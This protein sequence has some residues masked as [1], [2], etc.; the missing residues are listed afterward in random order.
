MRGIEK[1]LQFTAFQAA[2]CNEKC[3]FYAASGQG[4]ASGGALLIR[5]EKTVIMEKPWIY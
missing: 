3:A 4:N 2:N 1:W 5:K